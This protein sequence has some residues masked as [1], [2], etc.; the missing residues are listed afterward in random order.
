MSINLDDKRYTKSASTKSIQYL[1]NFSF[2]IMMNNKSWDLLV[3][4]FA[5]AWTKHNKEAVTS[6]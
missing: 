6:E 3:K 4:K 2:R 5:H 1:L